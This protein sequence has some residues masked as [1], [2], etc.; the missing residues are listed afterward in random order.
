MGAAIF[1]IV[2]ITI[3]AVAILV[4]Y[5]PGYS[6]DGYWKTLGKALLFCLLLYVG[7]IIFI[8]GIYLI[9]FLLK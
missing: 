2:W 6:K 8:L 5:F 3:V 7:I 1:F 4:P 9:I